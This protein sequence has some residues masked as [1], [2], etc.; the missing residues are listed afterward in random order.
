MSI[1]VELIGP[2]HFQKYENSEWVQTKLK[3]KRCD[4]IIW[5]EILN[6]SRGTDHFCCSRMGCTWADYRSES[7][8]EELLSKINE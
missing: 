1:F 4:Q 6:N 2:T 8:M 7:E 5:R 3:C